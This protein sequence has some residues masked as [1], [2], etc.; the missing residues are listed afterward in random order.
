MKSLKLKIGLTVKRNW[1]IYNNFS[2][3]RNAILA[4]LRGSVMKVHVHKHVLGNPLLTIKH[5][6]TN[7]NIIMIIITLLSHI[8]IKNS[9]IIIH[10]NQ[11]CIEKC[12]NISLIQRYIQEQ[13]IYII[14]T[15]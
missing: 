2:D 8:Y 15:K 14:L 13:S 4:N 9:H 7:N 3:N 11:T 12:A 1:K 5:V 10:N 6:K